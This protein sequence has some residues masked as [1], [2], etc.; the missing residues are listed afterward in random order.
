MW[1][2]RPPTIMLLFFIRRYAYVKMLSSTYQTYAGE[3]LLA[4]EGASRFSIS[5]FS[6][7]TIFRKTPDHVGKA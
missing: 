4:D 2:A 1:L 5:G 3:Y 7:P 6:S